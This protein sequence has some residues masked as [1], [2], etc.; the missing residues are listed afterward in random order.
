MDSQK[1]TGA[2]KVRRP[3]CGLVALELDIGKWE[4]WVRSSKSGVALCTPARIRSAD[5]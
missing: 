5:P 3:S 1:Q 2:L 4:A